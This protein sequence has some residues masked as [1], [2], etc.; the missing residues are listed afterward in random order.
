MFYKEFLRQSVYRISLNYPRIRTCIDMLSDEEIWH[1]PN[2]SSNSVGNLVLHLCG[3]M[4]QYIISALGE[5]EDKRERDSEFSAREGYTAAELLDKMKTVND[6][7]INM[8]NGLD[9][10]KLMREYFIQGGSMSGIGAVVHITEHYSYHTGQIVYLTKALKD[11]DT[12]FYKGADLNAK[13]KQ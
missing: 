9:E 5:N 1:R 7:C 4:T 2:Q 10:K 6:E 11:T 13:N 8:I 12:G 3:N